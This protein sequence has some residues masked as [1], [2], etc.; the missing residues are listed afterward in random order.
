M[1]L[2][3]LYVGSIESAPG[4]GT[5]PFGSLQTLQINVSPLPGTK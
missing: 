4:P 2:L 1:L 3:I 5:R